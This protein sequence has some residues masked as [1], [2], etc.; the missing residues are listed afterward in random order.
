M[1]LVCT[2]CR[3][4]WGELAGRCGAAGRLCA[5]GARRTGCG[6]CGGCGGAS[7]WTRCADDGAMSRNCATANTASDPV[8]A[9]G[10]AT[11]RLLPVSVCGWGG[12]AGFISRSRAT[13]RASLCRSTPCISGSICSAA[14]GLDLALICRPPS[15]R[16]RYVAAP[17]SRPP[18]PARGSSSNRRGRRW[19]PPQRPACGWGDR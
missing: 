6:G 1:R 17:P 15:D 11:P 10:A 19:G 8:S 18:P 7:A 16:A 3:S 5:R 14:G 2:A 13:L 9:S 12:I 4:V